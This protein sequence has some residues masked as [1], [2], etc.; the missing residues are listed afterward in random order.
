[1]LWPLGQE[2]ISEQYLD[3]LCAVPKQR[4]M[5]IA[6]TKRRDIR[7]PLSLLSKSIGDEP[8][9]G[10]VAVSETEIPNIDRLVELRFPHSVLPLS[11]AT[12]KECVE[13]I[14]LHSD[15]FDLASQR[16]KP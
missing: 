6:G 14:N 4:V 11:A 7:H 10:V 12:I 1:M 8:N 13:F 16:T 5:V 9:D 3:K 2:P 15:R